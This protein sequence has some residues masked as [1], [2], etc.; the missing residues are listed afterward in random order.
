M[1]GRT[2][3][4]RR[5]CM[6]SS[7]KSMRLG[8][9]SSRRGSRGR[10]ECAGLRVD[11]QSVEVGQAGVASR[12]ESRLNGP[13]GGASSRQAGGMSN[14]SRGSSGK[15]GIVG[16]WLWRRTSRAGEHEGV[17]GG[18]D[19]QDESRRDAC[20]GRG[21][22]EETTYLVDNLIV[23]P[24]SLSSMSL[25][26]CPSSKSSLSSSSLSSLTLGRS[27]RLARHRAAWA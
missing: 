20:A 7:E 5:A 26:H 22:R 17:E 4:W 3:A 6:A 14:G 13:A 2:R 10:R 18:V 23:P 12:E 11:D 21:W 1:S 15:S 16:E 24:F 8:V 25:R 19:R 9:A 27:R